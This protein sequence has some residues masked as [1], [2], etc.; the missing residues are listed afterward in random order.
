MYLLSQLKRKTG[1]ENLRKR[2][3]PLLTCSRLMEVILLIS[4]LFFLKEVPGKKHSNLPSLVI[5]KKVNLTISTTQTQKNINGPI[6]KHE[7]IT[8]HESNLEAI[9]RIIT[10]QTIKEYQKEE[11]F[12]KFDLYSLI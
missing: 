4:I 11:Y 9:I 3:K 5:L 12:A 10:E 7:E 6:T 2:R 1:T 8:D